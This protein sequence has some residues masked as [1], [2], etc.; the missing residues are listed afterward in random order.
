MG[1]R[2]E[3]DATL[4][5]MLGVFD[6]SLE[7][8]V[9][10]TLLLVNAETLKMEH[11]YFSHSHLLCQHVSQ[12]IRQT[13]MTDKKGDEQLATLASLGDGVTDKVWPQYPARQFQVGQ[14]MMDS[15]DDAVPGW[16]GVNFKTKQLY[17]LMRAE[18]SKQKLSKMIEVEVIIRAV[19]DEGTC[20]DAEMKLV[21]I[22]SVIDA[23]S[24]D[25]KVAMEELLAGLQAFTIVGGQGGK[26][27]E[28]N[29]FKPS[30]SAEK[31]ML[32]ACE[33][34]KQSEYCLSQQIASWD[35]SSL[36][37]CGLT[38]GLAETISDKFAAVRSAAADVSSQKYMG[39]LDKNYAEVTKHMGATPNPEDDEKAFVA[40]ME[41]MER[42]CKA[43]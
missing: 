5:A 43:Q 40:Y 25:E 42:R 32:S 30:A 39:E 1:Q 31:D 15:K 7:G 38:K 33:A 36:A 6:S 8:L 26:V 9:L 22:K 2:G 10:A 13:R 19:L 16:H 24:S 37:Q 28:G 17:D 41:K 23:L 21:Q 35:T 20:M 12:S 34:L 3:Y 27:A 29:P 4:D 14:H 18:L 11:T